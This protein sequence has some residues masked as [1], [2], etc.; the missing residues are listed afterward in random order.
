ME[1]LDLVLDEGP[2]WGHHHGH[3]GLEE[4]RQLV[5]EAL[6]A[7][8]GHQDEAVVAKDGGV[9]G[10]QLVHPELPQAKH[11]CEQLHHLVGVRVRLAE[12]RCPVGVDAVLRE[13]VRECSGCGCGVGG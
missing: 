8:R 4:G 3:P 2:Q 12:L 5:A 11:F 1:L 6:P 10:L 7:S 9:H 13:L